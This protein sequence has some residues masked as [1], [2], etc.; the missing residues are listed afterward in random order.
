[1]QRRERSG[2]SRSRR[3]RGRRREARGAPRGSC[4]PARSR[5]P[6]ARRGRCDQAWPDR[7]DAA[8]SRLLRLHS[9]RSRRLAQIAQRHGTHDDQHGGSRSRSPSLPRPATGRGGDACAGPRLIFG[10]F[11]WLAAGPGVDVLRLHDRGRPGDP[12]PRPDEALPREV[13]RDRVR[14]RRPHGARDPALRREPKA[15][16]LRPDRP[17]DAAGAP[18]R[19]G[20][21]LL[22]ARRRR[23][24]RPGP[25][26]GR[27]RRRRPRPGRLDDHP[28]AGQERLHQRRPLLPAQVHGGRPGLPARAGVAQA[29]DPHRLP[30][31]RVLRSPRVRRRGGGRRSTSGRT[32]ARCSRGRRPCSPAWSRG[33][34]STT[35]WPTPT[36]P[37]RG[38]T[39][40]LG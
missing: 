13:E 28:A 40:C 4:C 14:R 24:D 11:L 26:R 31:H 30:E 12:A 25:G 39:S 20:P 16:D 34:A 5:A 23:P 18:G 8:R 10:T 37:G 36:R 38:A 32:R 2:R 15:G 21:A 35:R 27:G 29:A 22:P 9:D 19:R 3:S 7:N 17:G 6:R 1:M 33:R